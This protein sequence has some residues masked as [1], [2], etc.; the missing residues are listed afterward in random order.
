V[1]AL[2]EDLLKDLSDV[3]PLSVDKEVRVL[4]TTLALTLPTG[5][6]SCAT[7][8]RLSTSGEV[9]FD[10]K[11]AD[12]RN[13][14]AAIPRLIDSPQGLDNGHGC[15]PKICLRGARSTYDERTRDGGGD[16]SAASK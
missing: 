9:V 6:G 14:E 5:Q 16:V 3:H 7:C 13:P 2:E 11:P 15:I 10:R 1:A 8:F 12:H 4:S